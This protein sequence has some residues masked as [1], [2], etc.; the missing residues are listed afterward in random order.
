MFA[1][2]EDNMGAGRL[3]TGRGFWE[4]E[5]YV[6]TIYMTAQSWPRADE[7]LQEDKDS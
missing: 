4:V 5:T 6:L 2:A 7:D 3:G 1:E